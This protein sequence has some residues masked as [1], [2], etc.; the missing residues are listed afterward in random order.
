MFGVN[1]DTQSAKELVEIF[2]NYVEELTEKDHSKLKTELE[3]SLR[4]ATPATRLE[5]LQDWHEKLKKWWFG[6]KAKFFYSGVGTTLY[7]WWIDE[8]RDWKAGLKPDFNFFIEA[9]NVARYQ[10]V[11]RNID[12]LE[13]LLLEELSADQPK[14]NRR[15]STSDPLTFEALFINDEGEKLALEIAQELKIQELVE[16]GEQ[17]GK[18]QYKAVFAA[19]WLFLQDVRP[20]VVHDDIQGQEA[21]KAIATKFGAKI[22]KNFWSNG[23]SE[24]L[25]GQKYYRQIA[26]IM[27]KR[28][29]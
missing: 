25:N 16:H 27:R 23:A 4:F 7:S 11:K 21:C 18:F 12:Y 5:V 14:E 28:G 22:G 15:K 26:T 1:K 2:L 8:M 9:T 3:E 29:N 24:S 13:Q 6:Y 10:A 17:T 19:L 20:N